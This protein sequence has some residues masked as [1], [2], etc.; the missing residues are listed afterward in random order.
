MCSTG[1]SA[2]C[3]RAESELYSKSGTATGSSC[4]ERC[5]LGVSVFLDISR[6]DLQTE[7]RCK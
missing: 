4:T 5:G 3:V 6:L 7:S 1:L 2:R